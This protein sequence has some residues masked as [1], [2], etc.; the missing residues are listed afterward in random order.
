MEANA[1]Y[2]AQDNMIKDQ[3]C[4]FLSLISFACVRRQ[5]TDVSAVAILHQIELSSA[6]VYSNQS[7]NSYL[8][9]IRR[10]DWIQRLVI[11]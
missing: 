1:A 5:G 8:M 11:A 4:S 3:P 9:K 7:L 10:G 6:K 2:D